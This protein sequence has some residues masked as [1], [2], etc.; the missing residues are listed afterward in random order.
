MAGWLRWT[1]DV[2]GGFAAGFLAYVVVGA[3]ISLAVTLAVAKSGSVCP[4]D[5][6]GALSAGCDNS[7]ARAFWHAVADLPGMMLLVP[8]AMIMV[9]TGPHEI[10]G[11]AAVVAPGV[12]EVPAAVFIALIV[13]GFFAWR[14]RSPATAWTLLV[15][16]AGEVALM[17]SRGWIPGG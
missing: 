10:T 12:L 6:Y 17:V 13:I 14:T 3:L 15:L 16:F 8:Y 9:L 7:F 5:M 1:R 2:V 11:N 4:T